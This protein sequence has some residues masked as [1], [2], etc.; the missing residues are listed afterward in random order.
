MCIFPSM[1]K[2]EL[3]P[4]PPPPAPVANVTISKVA[5]PTKAKKPSLRGSPSATL[6]IKPP[7]V[8]PATPTNVTGMG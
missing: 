7:Q 2:V 6:T 4:P 3:P 8:V 5:A 1:P